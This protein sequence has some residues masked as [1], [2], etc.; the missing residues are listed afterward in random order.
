MKMPCR[1]QNNRR[2]CA[3]FAV[4]GLE[5]VPE[6]RLINIAKL[7]QVSKRKTAEAVFF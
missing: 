3:N 5:A 4:F 7:E 2:V 6:N 1:K